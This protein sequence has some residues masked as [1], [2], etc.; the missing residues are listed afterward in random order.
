MNINI[1]IYIFLALISG[2]IIGKIIGQQ[3]LHIQSIII[4][5][6]GVI[7]IILGFLIIYVGLTEK[8]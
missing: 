8:F 2:F 3:S 5:A 7:A 4:I 1:L 6:C